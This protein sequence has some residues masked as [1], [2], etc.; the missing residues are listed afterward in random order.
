MKRLNIFVQAFMFCTLAFSQHPGSRGGNPLY[1]A[2]VGGISAGLFYI[3][4]ILFVFFMKLVKRIKSCDFNI[5]NF[6]SNGFSK[7][8]KNIVP[9][10]ED[11]KEQADISEGDSKPHVEN[12][13][14][15][16]F[17]KYC[18]KRLEFS[19]IYCPYCGKKLQGYSASILERLLPKKETIQR[20][21]QS[22]LMIAI[23]FILSL[24]ISI[25][26]CSII[27]EK[28]DD[29]AIAYLLPPI[30]GY[31]L[32]KIIVFAYSPS[33]S[34]KKLLAIGLMFITLAVMSI[35]TFIFIRQSKNEEAVSETKT[36]QIINRSF[37]GVSF[38]ASHFQ[39]AL[40]LQKAGYTLYQNAEDEI[41]L[42][43]TDFGKYEADSI[44]FNF[45]NDKFISIH[46][47]FNSMSYEDYYND[48]TYKSI[49]DLLE[50]KYPNSKD[51]TK[52]NNVLYYS[53][54]QTEVRLWHK[55][56]DKSTWYKDRENNKDYDQY[57]VTLTY[58]DKTSGYREERD[59][60]F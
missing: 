54:T 19:S 35:E 43:R 29:T 44:F 30:I 9:S 48:Y 5:T 2:L 53:D 37:L 18:G 45:Y 57:S 7:M 26:L 11:K 31:F 3:I 51:Y 28:N 21:V 12:D 50:K 60:D 33:S 38:G 47:V 34:R 58:Y 23:V 22:L 14:E 32:F 36:P 15:I 55:G 39:V 49:S 27:G 17:C 4:Y 41:C 1:W 16:H 52:Y 42:T 59:K 56:G 20:G 24:A 8:K 13:D 40:L 6:L 10:I 25:A 46:I